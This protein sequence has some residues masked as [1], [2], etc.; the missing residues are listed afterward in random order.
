MCC[1]TVCSVKNLFLG[2]NIIDKAYLRF[3]VFME[4]CKYITKDTL[5]SLQNTEVYCYYCTGT[6]PIPDSTWA[7]SSDGEEHQRPEKTQSA[8]SSWVAPS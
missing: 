5:Q 2:F 8:L 7:M 4:A 3:A 6:V 1:S